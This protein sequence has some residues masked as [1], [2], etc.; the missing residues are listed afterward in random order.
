MRKRGMPKKPTLRMELEEQ[1]SESIAVTGADMNV[2][3]SGLLLKPCLRFL[4]YPEC[5]PLVLRPGSSIRSAIEQM[6]GEAKYSIVIAE[7]NGPAIGVLTTRDIIARVIVLRKDLD[8][9]TVQ[10]VMTPIG[11]VEEVGGDEYWTEVTFLYALN[12]MWVGSFRQTF[13]IDLEKRVHVTIHM[14]SAIER[15]YSLFQAIHPLDL[16]RAGHAKLLSQLIY[17]S[18]KTAVGSRIHQAKKD[19]LVRAIPSTSLFVAARL[20]AGARQPRRRRRRP[21]VGCIL[22]MAR[23]LLKGWITEPDILEQ[24]LQGYQHLD[25]TRIGAVAEMRPETMISLSDDPTVGRVLS[26]FVELNADYVIVA[27]EQER[28]L[29]VLG[30]R[31]LLEWILTTG[32]IPKAV[33]NLPHKYQ[34][35]QVDRDLG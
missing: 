31:W 5:I 7:A 35:P 34:R 14:R 6:L 15:M 17:P 13:L 10:E 23:G 33:I 12:R 2:M 25:E 18:L 16:H 26:H 24:A 8:S 22:V 28:P 29:C 32:E 3:F 19:R 20:M 1:L 4:E 27:D 11:K 9:T 21:P 30:M